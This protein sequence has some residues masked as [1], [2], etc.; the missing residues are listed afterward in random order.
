VNAASKAEVGLLAYTSVLRAD[1]SRLGLAPEHKA[2]ERVIRESGLP[3]VFLRNGWYI[4]NYTEN[5]GTSLEHGTM[6]GS[7]GEGRIAAATRADYAEAAVAVLTGTG[8][9]KKIYELCGDASFTMSELA[10]EVSR[11]SGKSIAYTNLPPDQYRIALLNAGIPAPFAGLL[12]VS[13]LG[14]ARGELDGNS[15][16]LHQLIGRATTPLADAV[17]AVFKR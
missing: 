12:V 1:T 15:K 9:E 10:A 4:E 14:I 16:E 7:A 13:D 5:L 17:A 8:H 2:T 3:Y 6:I 11:R